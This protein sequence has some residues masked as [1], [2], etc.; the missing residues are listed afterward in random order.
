MQQRAK[1]M[2][3]ST[4]L[5]IDLLASLKVF[6]DE[7]RAMLRRRCILFTKAIALC[8]RVANAGE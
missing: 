4:E 7:S 6:A 3:A 5:R 2:N 8:Q 1:S